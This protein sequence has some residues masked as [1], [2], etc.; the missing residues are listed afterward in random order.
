MAITLRHYLC[1]LGLTEAVVLEDPTFPPFCY[2]WLYFVFLSPERTALIREQ[3]PL[4]C[5]GSLVA[6]NSSETIDVL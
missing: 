5:H 2:K 1:W 6:Q 4:I 3:I